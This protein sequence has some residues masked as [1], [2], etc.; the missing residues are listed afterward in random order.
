M[1][2]NDWIEKRISENVFLK[3][4][5]KTFIWFG[6][7]KTLPSKLSVRSPESQFGATKMTVAQ[8]HRYA[9]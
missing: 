9:E 7:A 5:H 8:G 3:I 6:G 2:A 4:R 1:T